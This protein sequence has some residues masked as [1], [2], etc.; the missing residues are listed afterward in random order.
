MD[1]TADFETN[2]KNLESIVQALESG[3]QPLEESVALYEKGVLLC[4][5]CA[6]QLSEY[7][8][9]LEPPAGNDKEDAQ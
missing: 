5:F 8:K 1:K 9:R 7:E 2:I 3:A 6:K 4:E